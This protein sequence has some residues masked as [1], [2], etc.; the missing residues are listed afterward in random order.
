M[1]LRPEQL[2]DHLGKT[3][4]PVYLITGDETYLAPFEAARGR[5]EDDL[6][7]LRS[8]VDD[9]DAQMA[10][11]ERISALVRD[12]LDELEETIQ[13]R[14]E[15]GF[16]AARA[17][18]ASGTGKAAMD[19]IRAQV[20]AMRTREGDVLY[21]SKGEGYGD[22]SARGSDQKMMQSWIITNATRGR[23]Q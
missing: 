18:V 21:A 1:K 7:A 6:T 9:N 10:D 20:D 23:S 13:V 3:L 8:L 19:R 12:K 5:L 22:W 14:R 15:D 11:A 4:A 16:D 2:A 17:I